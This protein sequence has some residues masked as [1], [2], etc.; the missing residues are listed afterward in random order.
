MK[1]IIKKNISEKAYQDY[2]FVQSVM[3]GYYYQ[4]FINGNKLFIDRKTKEVILNI[5]SN[6]IDFFECL[7]K[8]YLDKVIEIEDC[9]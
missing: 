2:G 1:I 5:N 9:L 4:T 8:M 7:L 3:T 6:S